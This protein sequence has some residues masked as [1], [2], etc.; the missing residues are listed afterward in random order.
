VNARN[1]PSELGSGLVA[2]PL[3]M[4]GGRPI[5]SAA[6]T[7]EAFLWMPLIRGRIH[8][9]GDGAGCPPYG[10]SGEDQEDD[11]ELVSPAGQ[12]NRKDDP[13]S[14]GDADTVRSIVL[15]SKRHVRVLRWSV[16]PRWASPATSRRRCRECTSVLSRRFVGKIV[17]CW[18]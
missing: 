15:Q 10:P 8:I 17:R 12:E 4:S 11:A 2:R 14:D 6:S 16:W 3:G 7:P 1:Q 13:P 5:C 18:P 9:S